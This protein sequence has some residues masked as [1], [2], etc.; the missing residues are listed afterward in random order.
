MALSR[1]RI[2]GNL[3]SAIDSAS[4]N[5]FLSKASQDGEYKSL[6]YSDLSGAPTVLDS[7]GITAVIDSSYTQLRITP[8]TGPT[9]S[10]DSA[11]VTSLIDSNFVTNR[12][13]AASNTGFTTYNYTAT[14]GQT[15]F[16]DSD[17]SGNILSYTA[18][19]T[20]VW[21]NGVMLKEAADWTGTDGSS[22]VLD[23]AANA[24]AKI[25]IAKWN[26]L[27]GGAA[28]TWYGD[29]AVTFNA[30][31]NTTNMSNIIEYYD[32][33]TPGNATDFGDQIGTGGFNGARDTVS[34]GSR[35]VAPINYTGTTGLEYV[36]SST[37]GNAADFGDMYN[38]D[39]GGPFC[40]SNGTY[41][42]LTMWNGDVGDHNFIQVITIATAGNATDTGYVL[43]QIQERAS[44]WGNS[45]RAV[46]GG[47]YDASGT[48]NIDTIQYIGMPVSA[49]ASDFGNLSVATYYKGACGDDT[50]AL[51]GG[52]WTSTTTDTIDYVTIA[53]TANASDFGDLT[54]ARTAPAA[55]SNGTIGTWNSGWNG[56]ARSNVIDYVT[57]ATPGNATD[58]GD[59]TAG[60][61]FCQAGSGSPS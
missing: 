43:T 29:R 10:V 41:G 32:I 17:L 45:T 60:G 3:A 47:G 44:G 14:G 21:M 22:I 54:V 37:P 42:Y 11:V 26:V 16:Q 36:T 53:T 5:S 58:H 15:T 1:N 34:N 12:A 27:A 28:A 25:T 57:I 55:A 61:H 46:F 31:G 6:A 18:G 30:S 19:G 2:I 51:W 50:Y 9:K 52:G 13:P 39:I 49:D 56:S 35:I 24:G 23:S 4:Q 33:T 7:A 59:M 8:A 38:W 20:M 40:A 48:G